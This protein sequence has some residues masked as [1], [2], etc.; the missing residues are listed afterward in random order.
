MIIDEKAQTFGLP[1]C[2]L[3]PIAAK[4]ERALER[5]VGGITVISKHTQNK[6]FLVN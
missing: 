5:Y 6:A 1:R 4:N 3:I 2:M